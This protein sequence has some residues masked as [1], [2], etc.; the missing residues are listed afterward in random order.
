MHVLEICLGQWHLW[1]DAQRSILSAL[2]SCG[3]CRTHLSHWLFFASLFS[4]L[5]ASWELC[6]FLPSA[7]CFWCVLSIL[8]QFYQRCV[9]SMDQTT[10]DKNVLPICLR[11]PKQVKLTCSKPEVSISGHIPISRE[12]APG[13]G[14]ER[15]SRK[16]R[17]PRLQLL[18]SYIHC[19]SPSV[20]GWR[21]F[22]Y[23]FQILKAASQTSNSSNSTP[24]VLP[25]PASWYDFSRNR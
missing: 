23:A 2:Q 1:R 6:C 12:A 14:L 22:K 9:T 3:Q 15:R 13:S 8:L 5:H 17:A 25:K 20:T 10:S 4:Q 19:Y 24:V 11:L 16:H 18:S 7:R 21:T